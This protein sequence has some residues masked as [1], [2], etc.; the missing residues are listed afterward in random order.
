MFC[1]RAPVAE[2]GGFSGEFFLYFEDFV[3]GLTCQPRRIWSSYR[4]SW[5]SCGP[6]APGHRRRRAGLGSALRGGCDPSSSWPG[7]AWAQMAT[8]IVILAVLVGALLPVAATGKLI[9]TAAGLVPFCVFGWLVLLDESERL[10]ARHPLALL[11]GDPS[12]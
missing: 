4:S 9:Y 7:R 8:V 3:V 10:R 2:I 12:R 11:S 1:P 5:G 6:C